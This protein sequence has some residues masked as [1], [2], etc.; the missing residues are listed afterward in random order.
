MTMR[1]IPGGRPSHNPFLVMLSI[2]VVLV[3]CFAYGVGNNPAAVFSIL[4]GIF[5]MLW[6]KE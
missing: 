1:P 3:G 4:V 6:A 2:V 5:L